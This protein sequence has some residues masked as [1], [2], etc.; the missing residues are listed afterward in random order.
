[1]EKEETK[2]TKFLERSPGNKSNSRRIAW[3][4][5]IAGLLFAQEVLIM[6]FF[7]KGE[8]NMVTLAA[9]SVSTFVG[10]AG[11]ALVFAFGQKTQEVKGG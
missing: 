2:E 7:Q 5:F 6:G 8:V 11:P 3:Y 10:I 9:A 1:M 4:A